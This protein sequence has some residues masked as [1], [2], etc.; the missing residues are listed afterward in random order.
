MSS[1]HDSASVGSIADSVTPPSQNCGPSEIAVTP[2]STQ[3]D[4]APMRDDS[5]GSGDSEMSSGHDSASFGTSPRS[6]DPPTQKC[7]PDEPAQSKKLGTQRSPREAAAT[8][9]DAPAHTSD[10]ARTPCLPT[11]S[12]DTPLSTGQRCPAA[13]PSQ[14]DGSAPR[15][16]SG[17]TTR[18]RA[19]ENTSPKAP[20]DPAAPLSTPTAVDSSPV[21]PG[22]SDT[23][24]I[25][26]DTPSKVPRPR[27]PAPA[28]TRPQRERR[29]PARYRQ[30]SIVPFLV[31]AVL[32]LATQS[33]SSKH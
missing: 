32:T 20:S 23:S 8:A 13:R 26:M 29:R 25:P 5:G 12:P 15:V 28:S 2:R 11:S 17:P 31:Q 10:S 4:F 9:A 1:G 21:G 19:K 24:T 3:D 16:P 27:V 33:V 6:V 18:S 7:G 30:L 22:P 14:R